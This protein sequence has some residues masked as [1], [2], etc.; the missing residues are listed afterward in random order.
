MNTMKA[1]STEMFGKKIGSSC[2]WRASGV[3]SAQ[4]C[5][6][7]PD[8]CEGCPIYTR[9][10]KA[11]SH[12]QT[13]FFGR[14]YFDSCS[15]NAC[16]VPGQSCPFAGPCMANWSRTNTP[17]LR[18]LT[19][20][21]IGAL[22]IGE[23]ASLI[24]QTTRRT[25][26]HAD[27]VSRVFQL[28]NLVMLGPE[29]GL[30][31]SDLALFTAEEQF[32]M[33]A[34]ASFL[35]CLDSL[36]V[37]AFAEA[38]M[39]R[40]LQHGNGSP[41]LSVKHDPPDLRETL[42]ALQG[43]AVLD[44]LPAFDI[45]ILGEIHAGMAALPYPSM[46]LA[47]MA[48]ALQRAIQPATFK[49]P[50]LEQRTVER[51]AT[52]VTFADWLMGSVYDGQPVTF[53][54][55][56]SAV[57]VTR[58]LGAVPDDGAIPAGRLLKA[59]LLR[60]VGN[61]RLDMSG[62]HS[63]LAGIVA[64]GVKLDPD[65]RT[66]FSRAV[67]L[68]FQAHF[69][70]LGDMRADPVSLIAYLGADNLV[71]DR[72]QFAAIASMEAPEVEA[73]PALL[74]CELPVD[75]FYTR[76]HTWMHPSRDGAL[77]VGLDDLAGHLIGQVDAIEMPEPGSQ[78]RRGKPALRL[79]RGGES[80]DVCA[81]MDGEVVLVNQAIIDAPGIL[82]DQPYDGGWLLS[83]RPKVSGGSLSGLLFGENAREWQTTEARR[84]QEMFQGDMATAADGA[85]LARD[86]LATIPGVR[87]SKV[88]RAFLTP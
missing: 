24:Q 71:R 34:A 35:D 1:H 28:R 84:L 86:A 53:P 30:S 51:A 77:R 26:L 19:M 67:V 83:I 11:A 18:M 85:T 43:L 37:A 75:R 76:G 70:K 21:G 87:W 44:V 80:V 31:P 12:R 46:A 6:S 9:L 74:G 60:M 5:E 55:L 16:A 88:L 3:V 62:A 2:V 10:G 68:S 50:A 82:P 78:L 17:A 15:V 59:E 47:Q 33:V 63:L 64:S 38:M 45:E 69:T 58:T 54:E 57:I 73:D 40:V 81:P 14:D 65:E 22:S 39:E 13:Q 61:E 42:L 56:A 4:M 41:S 32:A 79:I 7:S 23:N 8:S 52:L 25:G 29:S 27:L 20:I 72:S 36:D 66:A 49:S 48:L